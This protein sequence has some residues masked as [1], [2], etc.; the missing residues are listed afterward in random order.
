MPVNHVTSFCL[1]SSGSLVAAARL[2]EIFLHSLAQHRGN[3]SRAAAQLLCVE[4]VPDLNRC[5]D[6]LEISAG[7]CRG[8]RAS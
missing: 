6:A 3:S 4:A 7:L 2:Q 1:L 5:F 8:L